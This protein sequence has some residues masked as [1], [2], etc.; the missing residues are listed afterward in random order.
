MARNLLRAGHE[1]AVT[2][3]AKRKLKRWAAKALTS[4]VRLVK[5]AAGP[6]P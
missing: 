6:K 2:I 4:R 5:Y 3:E 1:V